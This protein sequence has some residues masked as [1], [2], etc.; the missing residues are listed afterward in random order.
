MKYYIIDKTISK[1]PIYFNNLNEVISHLEGSCK[2]LFGLSRRDY[3]LN[4][5][6]LGHASD[7]PT[8]KTFIEAMSSLNSL[9]I[10]LVKDHRLVRCNIFEATYYSQYK[11]EMGD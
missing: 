11:K 6:D 5:A 3:M 1:D 4:L 2:R 10:G 9:N 7:E 8:G